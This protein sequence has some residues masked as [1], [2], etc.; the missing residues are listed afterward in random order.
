MPAMKKRMIKKKS[1]PK[2]RK[3]SRVARKTA[4][5]RKPARRVRAS[6]ARKAVAKRRPAGRPAPPSLI[7]KEDRAAISAPRKVVR[8]SSPIPDVD[9]P[10]PAQT[11]SHGSFDERSRRDPDRIPGGEGILNEQFAE[12]DHFTNKTGDPRIGT[13]RKY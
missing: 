6:T 4:S 13:H 5:I 12:V 3:R 8:A 1:A 2:A 7:R 10:T 9:L 11:S